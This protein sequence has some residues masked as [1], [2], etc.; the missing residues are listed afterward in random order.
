LQLAVPLI[1]LLFGQRVT[2]GIMAVEL[3]GMFEESPSVAID[4]GDRCRIRR[5]TRM[6]EWLTIVRIV[7]SI[8]NGRPMF[9]SLVG[10][11]QVA[12]TDGITTRSDV[13]SRAVT[14]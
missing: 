7:R 14:V 3:V 11:K 13:G 4:V 8:V 5:A 9:P 1:I 2:I 10:P 12:S 6:F